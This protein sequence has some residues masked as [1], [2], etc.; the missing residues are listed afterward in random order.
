ML[1]SHHSQIFL[2]HLNQNIFHRLITGVCGSGKC[3]TETDA[4][5]GDDDT[6]DRTDDSG[7]NSGVTCQCESDQCQYVTIITPSTLHCET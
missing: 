7:I 5:S 6:D 3:N 2:D 1:W 4:Y